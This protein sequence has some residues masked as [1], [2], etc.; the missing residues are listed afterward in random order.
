MACGRLGGRWNGVPGATATV[1]AIATAFVY[2]QRLWKPP[3]TSLWMKCCSPWCALVSRGLRKFSPAGLSLSTG[4]VDKRGSK[5]VHKR[6][7]ASNDAALARIAQE[8]R[9]RQP[10]RG[11]NKIS[12]K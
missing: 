11:N 7:I 4:P 1:A 9:S 5:S 2:P 8:L 12:Y 10:I 6:R 3:V